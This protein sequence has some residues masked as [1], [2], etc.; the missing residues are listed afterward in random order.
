VRRITRY[1]ANLVGSGNEGAGE[2]EKS[3][4]PIAED[5]DDRFRDARLGPGQRRG[6]EFLFRLAGSSLAMRFAMKTLFVSLILVAGTAFGQTYQ[7]PSE[8]GA[9]V[10]ASCG[11]APTGYPTTSGVRAPNTVDVNGNACTSGGGGGGSNAAAGPTGSAVPA[12][13][14]YTGM[15]VGGTLTG[16]TATNNGGK[17]AADVNV[18]NLPTGASTSA[19]QT[20]GNTSLSDIDTS[21]TALGAKTDAKNSATDTTSVSIVSILK[22]LSS[23]AQVLGQTTMSASTAVAVASDQSAIPAV[24]KDGS[25][26]VQ[27]AGDTVARR[28]YRQ[29]TDG[30][31]SQAVDPCQDAALTKTNIN[32]RTASSSLTSLIAS[33]AAKTTYICWLK[34]EVDGT[35][36]TV[37]VVEAA[38]TTTACD[39]SQTA[40]EGSTT[41]ASGNVIAA[42]SGFVIGNAGF[43]AYKT[44]ATAHEVCGLTASTN[45]VHYTGQWVAR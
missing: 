33:Q 17:I 39:G 24:P 32:V 5:L 45:V 31:N 12:D 19:L 8:N 4:F 16:Q 6:V 23:L 11:T 3:Q 29:L 28:S 36:E 14:S 40:L 30:T 42:N 41:A 22:E 43:A 26:N 35:G 38:H 15:S 13:A 25:G 21:T 1:I 10:V 34:V 9:V 2:C 37:S 27:P 18:T 7:A 20:T 44:S